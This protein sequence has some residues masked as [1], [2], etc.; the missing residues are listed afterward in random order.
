MIIFNCTQLGNLLDDYVLRTFDLW[1]RKRRLKKRIIEIA[2][3]VAWFNGVS[4]KDDLRD[5]E[6]VARFGY[7]KRLTSEQIKE[8]ENFLSVDIKE[9]DYDDDDGEGKIR[10]LYMYKIPMKN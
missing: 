10:R 7:W 6:V 1:S 2:E 9:D 8:L 5:D 3:K 4:F